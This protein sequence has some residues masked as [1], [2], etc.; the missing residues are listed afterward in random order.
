MASQKPFLFIYHNGPGVMDDRN[1]K[2]KRDV[3]RHVML[4][5][6]RARRKAYR[7]PQVDVMIRPLV[8]NTNHTSDGDSKEHRDSRSMPSLFQTQRKAVPPEWPFWDRHP[9]VVL[10][11]QWDMD[12]FSAYGIA[13]VIREGR[14]IVSKNDKP[15]QGGFWFPFAFR[16]SAFLYHFREALTSPRMLASITTAVSREFQIVALRRMS[17]TISCIGKILS[18]HDLR[19]VTA[20]NVIRG[21][22]ACLELSGTTDLLDTRDPSKSAQTSRKLLKHLALTIAT[23]ACN[24]YELTIGFWIPTSTWRLRLE[25]KEPI[26]P[27]A[28]DWMHPIRDKFSAYVGSGVLKE[29]KIEDGNFADWKEWIDIEEGEISK[30]RHFTQVSVYRGIPFLQIKDD[31]MYGADIMELAGLK[32]HDLSVQGSF[33]ESTRLVPGRTDGRHDL[34]TLL[35]ELIEES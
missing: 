7:N 21:V 27:K 16:S 20:N 32:M 28:V 10:E 35:E 33:L 8:P 26:L 11:R 14:H 5:I 22:L 15:D 2:V 23:Q 31:V 1:K 12:T 6:G 29:R 19:N 4:D 30:W 3:R 17:G 13:F 18:G 25:A 9:L 34:K 24:T